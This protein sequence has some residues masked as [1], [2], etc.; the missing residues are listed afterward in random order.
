M[1]KEVVMR[2]SWLL[3]LAL[4]LVPLCSWASAGKG[5]TAD[6]V[7]A[8]A[9]EA[10]GGEERLAEVGTIEASGSIELLGMTG[11]Y[12]YWAQAPDRRKEVIDLEIIHLERSV[13]AKEG[14]EKRGEDVKA[15]V[16]SDLESLRRRALFQPLLVFQQSPVSPKLAGR[17]TID[18][19][20]ILVV[21]VETPEHGKETIYFDAESLLPVR[22]VRTVF[23][24]E[25]E[26]ALTTTWGDYRSVDG[27]L[28]PFSI[29]TQRPGR[30]QTVKI[31]GYRVGSPQPADLYQNPLQVDIDA[32]FEIGLASI[33][34]RVFKENDGVWA[35]GASESWV[36]HV[37]VDEKHKRMVEPVSAVADL[38]ADGK[39]VKT[40]S[41]SAAALEAVQEV[42]FKGFST[43]PEVFDLRHYFSE[44]VSLEID[45]LVYRLRVNTAQGEE[46]ERT[47]EIPLER[48]EQQ[49]ELLLPLEGRFVVAG[50]HAFNEDHRHERSQ[51]YADDILGLG[52]EYQLVRADGATNED[53]YTWGREIV[54]PAGGKVVYARNDVPDNPRPGVIEAERFLS[55]PDPLHAIGGNMV[56]IDHGNGEFSLLGHMMKG[57]VRVKTGDTVESGQLLGL[58]GNSGN[59][60]APHLHYHLMAGDTLFQSDG[61]PTRFENVVME[62]FTDTEADAIAM[63]TPK[64]GLFL[65]AR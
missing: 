16:G 63:P 65:V 3:S 52:P 21:D 58:V 49:T 20:Q 46:L 17:E 13:A 50:G 45:L 61:L 28:L 44:P 6:E 23:G 14:W 18:G 60:D 57:S 31:D 32:S 40:V 48:Y 19:R 8:R 55:L 43:Q 24:D 38:H 25:G 53:Y 26:Y 9:V 30:S 51:F 39:L 59:S 7:L 37:L 12:E 22:E 56:V 33:P 62:V 4:V 1:N 15:L 36:V 42:S 2:G 64:R 10:L 54:A 5:L 27:L 41:Y 34:R 35:E 47:L 29:V 11:S